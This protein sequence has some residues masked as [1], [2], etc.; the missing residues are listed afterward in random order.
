MSVAKHPIIIEGPDGGGKTHLAKRVAEEFD[1]KYT[2]PPDELLSSTEGPGEGLVEWWDDELAQGDHYLSQRVYDRCFYISDAIY[3][4]AQMDRALLCTGLYYAGGIMK[5]WNVEPVIIFCLPPV[6]I[7]LANIRQANRERLRGVSDQ[8]LG[9]VYN[10]YWAYYGMW[11]NALYDN[12]MLY[13]Y[14]DSAS[15][16]RLEAHVDVIGVTL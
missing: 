11:V 13:D 16:E 2:R 9:K 3:Q 4:M 14:T 5:L 15:W 1:R 8:A 7:T 12:I 6:D 10:M